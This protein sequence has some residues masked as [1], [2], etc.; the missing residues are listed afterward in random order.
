[1]T[2][3][4]K[5]D[6]LIRNIRSTFLDDISALPE[7]AAANQRTSG[8]LQEDEVE[9]AVIN[10]DTQLRF[11][12]ERF[13]SPSSAT[14]ADNTRT[15]PATKYSYELTGTSRR[16]SGKAALFANYFH[17][18]LKELALL[19]ILKPIA[20]DLADIHGKYATARLLDIEKL[21]FTKRP[22]VISYEDDNNQ[23]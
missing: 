2:I 3:E 23:P 19:E 6:E 10:A 22:P 18:T 5:I 14:S 9:R 16:L 1:M 17:D 21:I 13:L 7:S 15:L 11:N 8:I 20:A 4:I 12:L